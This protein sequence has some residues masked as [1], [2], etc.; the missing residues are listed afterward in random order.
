MRLVSVTAHAFR[1]LR[2]K[3]LTLG[4]GLNVVF[5]PNGSGKTTWHAA[6][7]AALCGQPPRPGKSPRLTQADGTPYTV[8][9]VV[10]LDRH[11]Q[12]YL[13]QDLVNPS[14]STVRER[15]AP[16]PDDGLAEFRYDGGV[17]VMRHI[18]LDWRTFAATAWVE[19]RRGG[20]FDREGRSEL[21]RAVA[22]CVGEDVAR[23]ACEDMAAARRR[24]V[25]GE[26]GPLR[27]AIAE[28]ARRQADVAVAERLQER[29]DRA[30][31]ALDR[32]RRDAE[33]QQRRL[34]TA[35]AAAVRAEA[36]KLR[37][38]ADRLREQ[39]DGPADAVAKTFAA[40]P[41]DTV[42][43]RHDVEVHP[44]VTE[45]ERALSEAE[46]ALR[47]AETSPK[48]VQ[49]TGWRVVA[50]TPPP[51]E[52]LD[53]P[54][55]PLR[56]KPIFIG[57]LSGIA[58]AAL[59]FILWPIIG[60]AGLVLGIVGVVGA[61]VA[62]AMLRPLRHWRSSATNTGS[63]ALKSRIVVDTLDKLPPPPPVV[64]PAAASRRRYEQERQRLVEA[65]TRRGYATTAGNALVDLERYKS[66]TDERARRN[67]ETLA[68]RQEDRARLAV[69]DSKL[70]EANR[71]AEELAAPADP[72]GL[73]ALRN[74]FSDGGRVGFAVATVSAAEEAERAAREVAEAEAAATEADRAAA[75]AERV[76]RDAE[77][78]AARFVSV[79]Q[80]RAAA[81]RADSHVERL[82]VLDRTLATAHDRLNLAGRRPWRRSRPASGST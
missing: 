49:A 60:T 3:T 24:Y 14:A 17:D 5:G 29:R 70:A 52:A 57:G 40:W 37:E 46:A 65:L 13:H 34:T 47:Q 38:E 6:M 51:A 45:A 41:G 36:A 80:A 43:A 63:D 58:L 9:A 67:A 21:Q 82:R 62:V 4:D 68:R 55:D 15:G 64:D 72:Y 25:G 35:R 76:L 12:V 20:W 39:V 50:A 26:V 73:S 53:D 71:R 44:S 22:L 48:P 81:G 75:G 23:R 33:Q 7:Y 28:L 32:C 8:D 18:D 66:E 10:A 27:R 31:E 59:G 19:Q 1:G 74:T 54:Y 77:E 16:S 79:E 56:S 78:E 61:L 42:N 69:L 30:F 11:R 2:S